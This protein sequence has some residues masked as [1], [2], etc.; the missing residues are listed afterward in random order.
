MNKTDKITAVIDQLKHR[1]KTNDSFRWTVLS[2]AI[3]LLVGIV[4]MAK[5][6]IQTPPPTKTKHQQ[7]IDDLSTFIPAGY[8]LIPIRVQNHASL[9]QVI[10]Q[11]AIVDLFVKPL[12]PQKKPF[13]LARAV[14]LVRSPKN[15]NHFAVLTPQEKANRLFAHDG[16]I[17][18]VVKSHKEV[19][20]DF[21]LDK[22]PRRRVIVVE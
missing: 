1:F 13:Q 22:K 18:A 2:L 6:I 5:L 10:G 14:R 9:D 19:G 7:P 20:T 15:P 17:F 3:A 8:S 16:E 11:F 12:D 21:D 4:H